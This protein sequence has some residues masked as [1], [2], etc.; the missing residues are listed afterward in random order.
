MPRLAFLF[1]IWGAITS[2]SCSLSSSSTSSSTPKI[3]PIVYTIAG[4]DSGGGAGIQAD[5]H[6]IHA[7]NCHGC[8][9]I[10]CLT[11]QN[12]VGVTEV[13]APPAS[14]LQTQLETLADDLAPKAVK[15][16]M[17]GNEELAKTVGEQDLGGV[18]SRHD[19]HFRAQTH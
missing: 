16:G 18:G 10:T 3:P 2:S 9:A 8:S 12:S 1:L 4:S 13:H 6:A 14:F 17:L 5:L 11:A 19:F 7:M 15:I